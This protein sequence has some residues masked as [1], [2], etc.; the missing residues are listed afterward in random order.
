MR[1][2]T[3]PTWLAA[4]S[5]SLAL[6]PPAA[7]A[8]AAD[9]NRLAYLDAGL[10]PYYPGL[11]SPKL[12]TPQWVGEEGVDAVVVLAIDD[13]RDN[14]AKYEQY[15]RPILDRLGRIDGRA[16][17]SIMT[18]R[19]AADDPQVRAWLD[20]G[21][22]IEVH[23][24]SH[25]CPL[26]QKGDFR[27][28]RDDVHGGIDLLARLPGGPP[29]AFR[30]P[31]CD[32]L[33]TPSPRFFAEIFG[34]PTPGGHSLAIDS[35]VF[36][37]PTADDPDLPR[38]LVDD[39]DGRERFRKYLPFPSFVNTIENYPYPYVIGRRCWEFPC[40][41]PSDWEAQNLHG[42]NNPKTVEDLKAALDAVVVKQ[43]VFNLVFH[44]H[45]WIEASQVVELID[46][47][48]A[49]HGRRVKFLNFREAKAR[50]DAHLLAGEPLRVEDGAAVLDGRVPEPPAGAPPARLNGADNGVRLL[51]LDAD[52]FLDVVIANPDRRESRRWD[53]RARRWV[54]SDFPFAIVARHSE[55]LDLA[56]PSEAVH[57]GVVRP[58]GRASAWNLGPIDPGA[59]TFDGASWR[60]DPALLRGL[61]L[62][63]AR[64]T[65][66]AADLGARL[67]DLDGDGRCE[68]LVGNHAGS[69]AYRWS[70]E[71]DRWEPL[72]FGLPPGTRFVDQLDPDRDDDEPIELGR[73]A[74]LRLVDLDEDGRLDV[75]F[76]DDRSFGV[77]LFASMEE[78]WSRQVLAGRRKDEPAALPAIVATDPVNGA[79]ANAGA[80]VHSRHLW[81]QN[82]HT[83]ALPNL[84]DRRSFHD[85]LR[86]VEPTARSPEASLRSIRVRPGFAVEL[87]ASEP[88]VQ[89]PIAFDW[90]PDGRLWVVEMGDYPLGEDGQGKPAGRVRVLED[91]DGDG[92]Y[93]AS[94]VF[95]D[96]LAF[97]NGLICWRDGV[98]ISVAPDFLYAADADGDGRADRTEVLFTGFAEANQQHRVNGFALGLDGWLYGADAESAEGVKSLRTGET[99]AFRGRDFRVDP[100]RGRIE[101]ES[102]RGQFG[103]Q[104]D[105]WG[106]WFAN[107]NSVWAWQVMLDDAV[108]RRN[109][110]LAVAVPWTMLEPD[111]RLYPASR[112]LPRFNDFNQANRV[113]SAN[114]PSPYRDDLFGPAFARSLFVS[115][116]VHNLVH[117]MVLEP[118]GAA[119]AGARAPDE[120]DREF[121][122]SSDNW[123]RPTQI[124]TGP[125]G[126]LW[127]ADM[128]RFVIEHPEWI[129]DDWEARLDLRAG[130]DLGRIYRVYPVGRR[131]RPIPR[132]DRLD[133]EGLA[134]AMD[135]P[136]GWVRDTSQRLL[137]HG[138][139]EAEAAAP[140]L[141][142]LVREAKHPQARVQALATLAC[143]GRLEPAV[144][145]SALADPHP[146]VRRFAATRAGALASR[147]EALAEGLLRLASDPEPRVRLG[148][149]LGL[150]DWD[151]PRAGLALGRLLARDGSDAWLRTAALSSARPQA[152]AVLR[153]LFA[154][155]GTEPPAPSVL[156]P[157]VATLAASGDA[158]GLARALDAI[159]TPDADGRF[160]DWQLAAAVAFAEASGSKGRDEA[161][162]RAARLKEAALTI[163]A[164]GAESADRRALAIRLLRGGELSD[165]LRRTLGAL[166]RPQE[167]P[168]IRDAALD[169]LARARAPEVAATLLDG[170][171]GYTPALRSA[172]LD[173]LVG[174]EAWAAALLSSLEDGCIP[175]TEVGPTHR[176]RLLEHADASIRDR[177]R[178]VF[179]G[180]DANRQQVVDR[181][182]AAMADLRGDRA[183]GAEVFRRACATCHRLGGEGSEVGPDLASLTDRG[184]EALL[185]AILDPNRSVE[186]TY[187]E[188]TVETTDG[189]ILAGL[190][191]AETSNALTLRRAEGQED[192]LTRAEIEAVASS[193]RSLMP[194][195]LEN[196]LTP[197]AVADVIAFVAAAGPPPK[198]VEG[199]APGVVEPGAGGVVTLGASR[200]EIYGSS[201]TFEPRF[202]NLGWWS[203]PDDRAAWEFEVI[204][205][206]RYEVWLDWACHDATAG[207]AYLLSVSGRRLGGTVAGT[208][209]WE[210]YRKARVGEVE[211]PAGR[212]RLEVAPDGPIR[213]GALIDLRAVELRPSAGG[214]G[215][216]CCGPDGP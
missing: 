59:W 141:A 1:P 114:S 156:D 154:A 5:L 9:G 85:L 134:N 119:W 192:V 153:G 172:A 147:S 57:F 95:L 196:D 183:R 94:T 210:S 140:T 160:A 121:L 82:E 104:R 83:A 16:P 2:R 107:N 58:G 175:P 4:C 125:D 215:A 86:D 106:D 211:L 197:E 6:T 11:H 48:Q 63:D 103:R 22:S 47:A 10:D 163:L 70:D 26:L 71:A 158:D 56:Y 28:A 29:V 73:D 132:L 13:M 89:D 138:G 143:L 68:F 189:R 178:A 19:V 92:R 129:P 150:G 65:W 80:W 18:N 145:A 3:V 204:R 202:G 209:D 115:E 166:L 12:T 171:K 8:P 131:P 27:A 38:P 117:R 79:G 24:L 122:A 213:G 127:I 186:P 76:S 170:W 52:G 108:L 84:V 174:R 39:P 216:P 155:L 116:P 194:E 198:R 133:P 142:R 62:D 176:R 137:L 35:S 60:P 88:L 199:N 37:I 159:A 74:G 51:D 49:T 36:N 185:A 45:G 165:D 173:A 168:A 77:Y 148:A 105:D 61:D 67:R 32:S 188:Y 64:A 200:A 128:Y 120:R 96:G 98:L 167:P 55:S 181:Y 139:G 152:S 144:A 81:W 112:T 214:A 151:D 190:I 23:T 161:A 169:A 99:T 201:L 187:A 111:G 31:C 41:V 193:G 75:V 14:T 17:V 72:P 136:N 93:D 97:P 191:A 54:A 46:H 42:P 124:K 177:A 208:G 135:S 212:H 184:P 100:D 164:D 78:G 7:A 20:E 157:L 123:F 90:S 21:L 102:G 207:N 113:T 130:H 91:R 15:L 40:V 87:V 162:G 101:P 110:S 180:T 182:R 149:A 118:V 126:A 203:A 33:N 205:P 66:G 25:P 206:G 69:R 146:E 50:L 43:G 53:P 44:P 179:E 109:P 30:M 195:G 34:P